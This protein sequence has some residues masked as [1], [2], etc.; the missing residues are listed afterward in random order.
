MAGTVFVTRWFI[1]ER[2][3][4][5]HQDCRPSPPVMLY[6]C[7]MAADVCISTFN[8]V[9]SQKTNADVIILDKQKRAKRARKD[10]SAKFGANA[11]VSSFMWPS[12]LIAYVYVQFA[13]LHKSEVFSS[14]DTHCSSHISKH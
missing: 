3:K 13:F 4:F 2:S 9:V 11:L 5:V 1:E 12:R 10:H 14:C 8:Y 6:I 7:G